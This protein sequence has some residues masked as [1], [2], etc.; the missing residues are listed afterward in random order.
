[1]QGVGSL[2]SVIVVMTCLSIGLSDGFTWRF[3]LAFGAVPVM[4][5]FPFRLRMHETETFTRVEEARK[6]NQAEAA[7]HQHQHSHPHAPGHP[8][9]S[10]PLG[11][12]SPAGY[13]S[14]EVH[15]N[16]FA[17]DYGHGRTAAS[18]K[19]TSQS[20]NVQNG[21]GLSGQHHHGADSG[22]LEMKMVTDSVFSGSYDYSTKTGPGEGDSGRAAGADLW[23]INPSNMSSKSGKYHGHHGSHRMNVESAGVAAEREHPSRVNELRKAFVYYKWH[24]LGTALSWFLL[25]VDFYANGLFNQKIT[26]T[27]FSVPGQQNSALQDAYYAGILSLIGI[28]GYYLSVYYIEAVG[29]KRLQ[30]LGFAMMA[31]LFCTCSVFYRW[32]MDPAG[33]SLR[34]YAFL[35]IYALTFLFRYVVFKLVAFVVHCWGAVLRCVAGLFC[36]FVQQL[37]CRAWPPVFNSPSNLLSGVEFDLYCSNFGPNTT[38]FVIPGEI[39]P[40]EVSG[41]GLRCR[42]VH[43]VHDGGLCVLHDCA[44]PCQ[45]CRAWCC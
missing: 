19:G 14:T 15:N 23:L 24:I 1:M 35:L 42:A 8:T 44:S 25:D 9:P 20:Q 6:T 29:R 28:P 2:L 5:A 26:S 22:E 27:I 11:V 39:F 45:C 12:R 36:A 32:L 34:K 13:G 4:C 16:L 40:A 7:K 17:D 38:S 41:T 3:A 43:T 33:G 30:M 31:L 37:G 21:F 18:T 10:T